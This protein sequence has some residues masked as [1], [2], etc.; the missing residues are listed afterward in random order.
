[1][2]HLFNAVVTMVNYIGIDTASVMFIL[3]FVP[4]H[5]VSSKR[6]LCNEFLKEGVNRTRNED[7]LPEC[8]SKTWRDSVVLQIR[9][10]CSTANAD[11]LEIFSLPGASSSVGAPTLL[12]HHS[13]WLFLV[14][15]E[16]E[17]PFRDSYGNSVSQKV[18]AQMT[19]KQCS[20]SLINRT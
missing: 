11:C 17:N 5:R 10:I 15:E 14:D 7:S 8:Q 4:I 1:M 3:I 2:E 19:G 12:C 6:F 20:C 16:N 18:P 9:R 13:H